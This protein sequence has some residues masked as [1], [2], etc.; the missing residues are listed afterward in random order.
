[1]NRK[2]LLLALPLA[3]ALAG[4]DTFYAEAEQPQVCLTLQRSFT[5]S[6][7]GLAEP[8]A[9]GVGAVAAIGPNFGTDVVLGLGSY[10]PDFVLQGPSDQH[11]LHFLGIQVNVDGPPGANFSWL[12]DL[13]VTATSGG[14]PAVLLADYTKPSGGGLITSIKASSLAPGDNL[15]DLLQNGDLTLSITGTVDQS[16][17][18][19]GQT[20]FAA[21]LTP[22]FSAKVR[23]TLGQLING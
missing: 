4:C 6:F 3:A 17:F 8:P 22:C 11:V 21:T 9:A 15:T 13:Q 23:K 2:S 12:Q 18:P 16:L 14:L 5:V 1:M 19:A 20:S 10:L 7:T